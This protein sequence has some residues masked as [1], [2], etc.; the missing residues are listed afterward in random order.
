MITRGAHEIICFLEATYINKYSW[1]TN[2]NENFP[3]I[4]LYNNSSLNIL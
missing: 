1:K 4:F 2:Q 3:S